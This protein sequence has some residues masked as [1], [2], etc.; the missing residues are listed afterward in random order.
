MGIWIYLIKWDHPIISLGMKGLLY[1]ELTAIGPSRDVHSSLAVLIE[2][3]AMD[4]NSSISTIIDNM[5]KY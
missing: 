2:N 5:E 1:V 3:P 4:I